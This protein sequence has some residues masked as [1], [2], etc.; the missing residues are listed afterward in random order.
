MSQARGSQGLLARREGLTGIGPVSVRVSEIAAAHGS[1]S[2]P[3]FCHRI[4]GDLRR[5]RS[6]EEVLPWLWLKGI[7]TGAMQEALEALLGSE[8]KGLS[9]VTISRLKARWEDERQAWSE[10]DLSSKRYVCF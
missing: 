10:R 6:V 7:S 2:P 9:P 5:A 4:S 8:A 1:S 3:P